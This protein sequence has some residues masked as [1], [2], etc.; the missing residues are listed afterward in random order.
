M[1]IIRGMIYCIL[2]KYDKHNSHKKTASKRQWLYSEGWQRADETPYWCNPY[3]TTPLQ[4]SRQSFP[5]K[6]KRKR[7][8]PTT[9][10]NV[11]LFTHNTIL[12]EFQKQ[13]QL[14]YQET[15]GDAFPDLTTE[16]RGSIQITET[17]I[18]YCRPPNLQDLLT[19]AK[20]CEGKGQRVSAY[21]KAYNPSD[22][23]SPA[24]TQKPKKKF[25]L[26]FIFLIRST[27]VI[28]VIFDI[29]HISPNGHYSH[30][31]RKKAL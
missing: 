13:I 6:R 5:C 2:R 19:S 9:D 29:F 4:K 22:F 21:F 27:T 14:A 16:N 25:L 17:T 1:S 10:E 3:L 11:F 20:L 15:C 12:M 8:T 24:K 30:F 28:P 7:L 26:L 18:V 31:W 23:Q